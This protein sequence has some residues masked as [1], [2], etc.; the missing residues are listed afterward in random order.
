MVNSAKST[1]TSKYLNFRCDLAQ[2][3]GNQPTSKDLMKL[4][5]LRLTKAASKENATL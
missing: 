4:M 3:D 1:D 5:S 2:Y